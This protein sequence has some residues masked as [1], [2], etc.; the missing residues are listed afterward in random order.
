MIKELL[1]KFGGAIF[2]Y[3]A[4]VGMLLM[5]N[6]RFQNMENIPEETLVIVIDN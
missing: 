4:V 6:Y 1:K 2:F 5:I 3:A